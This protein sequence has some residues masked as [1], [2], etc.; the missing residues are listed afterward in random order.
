MSVS[1]TLVCADVSVS[2]DLDL[3][4]RGLLFRLSCFPIK[5]TSTAATQ[6]LLV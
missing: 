4:E 2:W 3:G 5:S 1:S 6:A